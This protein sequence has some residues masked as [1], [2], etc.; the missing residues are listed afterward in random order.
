MLSWWAV[1]VELCDLE[2]LTSFLWDLA[3]GNEAFELDN[4]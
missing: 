4:L 3:S 1:F 2:H